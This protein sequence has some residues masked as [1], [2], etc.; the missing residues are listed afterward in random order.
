MLL[1]GTCVAARAGIADCTVEDLQ[2]ALA[3]FGFDPRAVA[4]EASGEVG[5]PSFPIIFGHSRCMI[6]HSALHLAM[7][8]RPL[9]K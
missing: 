4:R 9:D 2:R 5:R 8:A 3:P 1:I 6:F 7:R